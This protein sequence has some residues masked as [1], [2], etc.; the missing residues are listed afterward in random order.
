M[1]ELASLRLPKLHVGLSELANV[2]G[3]VFRLPLGDVKALVIG[4]ADFAEHVLSPRRAGRAFSYRWEDPRHLPFVR[5]GQMLGASPVGSTET[6]G[7]F[8]GNGPN[9]WGTPRRACERGL[10]HGN[11]IREATRHTALMEADALSERW[12]VEGTR[13]LDVHPDIRNAT[14]NAVTDIVFGGA[15]GL[16]P[17][18]CAEL[19]SLYCSMTAAL[20]ELAGT[21]GEWWW[22]LR[23]GA[24]RTLR[25]SAEQLRAL[26]L[27]KLEA[28]RSSP[29]AAARRCVVDLLLNVGLSDGAVLYNLLQVLG[30]GHDTTATSLAML[31]YHLS[32]D[33]ELQQAVHQEVRAATVDDVDGS[34][35]LLSACIKEALRM[36]PAAPL[37]VRQA[38]EPVLPYEGIDMPIGTVAIV[39]PWLLGR[40]QQL[41]TDPQFFRPQ[42]FLEAES[43]NSLH[44]FAWIPFGY[45]SRS[46]VGRHIA[47]TELKVFA[48]SLLRRFRFTAIEPPH[49]EW[50]LT[51]R[52]RNGLRMHVEVLS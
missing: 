14:L 23:P 35:P 15:D 44:P 8:F 25:R 6:A 2:H 36:W 37:I 40:S 47:V 26:L 5:W 18:S 19:Q 21:P 46:C 13:T 43:Q 7:I 52:I 32:Q 11:A 51:L 31:L 49:V 41:W 39:A 42:R 10:L 3:P 28:R 16:D 9:H 33:Q 30:A 24:A 17:A 1:P 4:D 29:P 38:L 20:E 34:S 45:G 50:F 27:P 12:A 48:A 22:L